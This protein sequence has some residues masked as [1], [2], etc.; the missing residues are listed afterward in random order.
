M[1]PPAAIV[2]L[3]PLTLG[4][5]TLACENTARGVKEDG[6]AARASA[7]EKADEA[8]QVLQREVQSFQART[9]DKL[10]ELTVAISRLEGKAEEGVEESR[11][12]LEQKLEATRSRLDAL[13]A[14][15]R[16]EWEQAKREVDEGVADLGRQINEKLDEVGD[17]VEEKLE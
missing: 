2:L 16:A 13:G 7:S 5:L 14:A 9:R 1:K 12:R 4:A 17:R 10:G 11:S 8:E 6:R 15:S 3:A